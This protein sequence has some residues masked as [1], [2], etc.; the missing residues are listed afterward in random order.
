M[1]TEELTIHVAIEFLVEKSRLV[2]RVGRRYLVGPNGRSNGLER[3][4]DHGRRLAPGAALILSGI[5]NIQAEAVIKA[6]MHQGLPRPIRVSRGDWTALFWT[7]LQA[8]FETK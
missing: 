3:G 1:I 2:P 4:C 5:L 7:R 8:P 6:Y